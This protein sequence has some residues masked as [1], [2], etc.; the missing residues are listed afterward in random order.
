MFSEFFFG[1]FVDTNIRQSLVRSQAPPQCMNVCNRPDNRLMN[2]NFIRVRSLPDSSWNQQMLN[3]CSLG[4]VFWDCVGTF[5]VYYFFGG[6]SNSALVALFLTDS[7]HHLLFTTSRLSVWE[8]S[9]TRPCYT[10]WFRRIDRSVCLD[11]RLSI[12]VSREVYMD[13]S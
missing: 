3:E 12:F 13:V 2:P 1:K 7:V 10:G 5:P 11:V 9:V 8:M 6:G 4:M